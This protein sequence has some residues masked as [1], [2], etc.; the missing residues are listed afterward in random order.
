MNKAIIARRDFLRLSFLTSF[1]SLSGCSF[2]QPKLIFRGIPETIPVEWLRLLK[3]PWYFRPISLVRGESNP[4]HEAFVEKTDLI[5]IEDGW[6]N[7][8]NT[9]PLKKTDSEELFPLLDLKAKSFLRQFK[10]EMANQF[11]PLAVSPWVMVFRNGS[12]WLSDAYKSWDILLAESLKGKVVFPNSARIIISLYERMD[13]ANS[14]LKLRSQA[15]N[16]DDKNALNWLLSGKARVAIL[17]L[18][19]C[20]QRVRQDP[21]LAVVL[22]ES[23]APLN[24]TLLSLMGSSNAPFPKEWIK[25]C[26]SMPSVGRS[27]GRGWTPSFDHGRLSEFKYLIPEPYH[28]V[29]IPPDEVW[30]KCW[31][32]PP[33]SYAERERLEGVWSR[34]NS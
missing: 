18:N 24:W 28:S 10:E 2:S 6:L 21:R 23:G 9:F 14:L 29:L 33:L 20:L 34:S 4:F 12:N 19:R 15:F 5:A 1:A 17:P 16:F 31:S 30:Q 22:P 8:L 32:L 13:D 26:W 3:N 11:F 7:A 25:Q 27:L